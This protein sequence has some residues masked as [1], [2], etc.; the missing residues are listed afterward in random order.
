MINADFDGN[1]YTDMILVGNTNKELTMLCIM[2]SGENRFAIKWE[3][4]S[5][6]MRL[7]FPLL[8]NTGKTPAIKLYYA[9]AYAGR[10]LGKQLRIDTLI[11]KYGT[12]VEEHRSKSNYKIEKLE[13]VLLNIVSGRVNKK[14]I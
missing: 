5:Y 8:I 7:F 2:D 4:S 11:Y 1:G 6:F 14:G 9:N 10:N 12:F 13:D 3:Y